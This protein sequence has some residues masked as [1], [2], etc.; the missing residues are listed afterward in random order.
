MGLHLP[1]VLTWLAPA[2]LGG[3]FSVAHADTLETRHAT[4]EHAGEH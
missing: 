1:N 3:F 4:I 2:L